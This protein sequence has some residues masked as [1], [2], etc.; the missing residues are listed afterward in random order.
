[1]ESTPISANYGVVIP[2]GEPGSILS[3]TSFCLHYDSTYT[4][5]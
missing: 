4:I 3:L 1:M 2:A 5:F